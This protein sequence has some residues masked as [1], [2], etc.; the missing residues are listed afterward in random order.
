MKE[1]FLGGES[2]RFQECTMDPKLQ[3][4]TLKLGEFCDAVPPPVTA[5]TVLINMCYVNAK[6]S[7][8]RCSFVKWPYAG[9]KMPV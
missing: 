3:N 5:A 6:K 7:C 8:F 1:G 2:L 4:D 9:A